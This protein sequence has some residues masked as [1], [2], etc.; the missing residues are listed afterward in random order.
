MKQMFG[1]LSKSLPRRMVDM[2]A[3][4]DGGVMDTRDLLSGTRVATV[5]GWRAVEALAAGDVVL[6]FDSGLQKLTEVR[7]DTF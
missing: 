2:S 3:A 7:R 5:M 1:W 6:T 4:C